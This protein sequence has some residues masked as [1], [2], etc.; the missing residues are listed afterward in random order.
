MNAPVAHPVHQKLEDVIDVD[1]TPKSASVG[2]VPE[3]LA[4]LLTVGEIVQ[5]MPTA[6]WSGRFMSLNDRILNEACDNP[7]AH[8][9]NALGRMLT[10]E[11]ERIK[12]IFIILEARCKTA[13]ASES[14][15]VSTSAL[16]GSYFSQHRSAF[17]EHTQSKTTC[18][19]F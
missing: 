11:E 1:A 2:G 12:V 15:G 13:A 5:S 19:N 18:H 17:A 9:E 4:E 8:K 16:L 3:E 7:R 10:R 14:L 6:Y